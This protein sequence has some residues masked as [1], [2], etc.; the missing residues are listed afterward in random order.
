MKFF[1]S[2]CNGTIF[3][4]RKWVDLVIID[5]HIRDDADELDDW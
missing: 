5:L 1:H 4:R 3:T 2:P